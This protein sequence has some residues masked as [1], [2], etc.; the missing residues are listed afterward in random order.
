METNSNDTE[1]KQPAS[2]GCYPTPCSGSSP[3]PKKDGWSH[4]EQVLVY[5]ESNERACSRYSVAYYHYDPPF[6][7]EKWTDFS[8]SAYGR[9]PLY[10][11]PLP[12]LPNMAL[13]T[14]IQRFNTEKEHE[15]IC[16]YGREVGKP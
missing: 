10:W 8:G 5:Y 7:S 13:D 16:E 11:W 3:P 1:A 12:S 6:E 15:R 4:S 2:A 14:L 9:S